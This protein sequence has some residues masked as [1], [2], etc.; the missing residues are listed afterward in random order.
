MG[1]A[2]R[3]ACALAEVDSTTADLTTDL[4]KRF[5][6]RPGRSSTTEGLLSS[7]RAACK[8]A[9]AK[10]WLDISGLEEA[11]WTPATVDPPRKRHHGRAEILQVLEHLREGSESWDGGRLYA[12]GSLYCYTGVRKVEGLR[13]RVT[14]VD[15]AQNVVFV[16][17]NGRP[18]KTPGSEAPVPLPKALARIL[19]PWID[20]CGSEWVF[21]RLDREGPWLDGSIGRRPTDRLKLAG[22]ACGVEGFTPQSLRHSLATHLAGYWGLEPR[23]IQLILRHTTER[24]QEHYVHPDV[25]NLAELVQGFDFHGEGRPR[26]ARAARRSHVLPRPSW[27]RQPRFM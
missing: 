9:A 24:T 5:A 14:D 17:P 19:R 11:I 8:L 10:S 25:A 1:Q 16:H 22:Q 26:A 21:P 27:S 4:V 6:G 7:L 18:L 13:L 20:R 3:E 23:Q 2:L 12:L 15:F